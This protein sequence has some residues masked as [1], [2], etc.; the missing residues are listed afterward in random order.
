MISSGYR[1]FSFQFYSPIG[2][3]NGKCVPGSVCCFTVSGS[4][5]LLSMQITLS[6]SV[7]HVDEEYPFYVQIDLRD[8]STCNAY[9]V[10]SKGIS[11]L[12]YY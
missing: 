10:V 5:S 6:Q 9:K 2:N 1:F 12:N 4:S 8:F 7:L 3:D 11:N